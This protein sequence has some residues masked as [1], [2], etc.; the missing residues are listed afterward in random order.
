MK[1]TRE[2]NY[3]I[4]D[5]K[6]IWY[7]PHACNGC[8]STVIV[9]QKNQGGLALDA[10]HNHHYPNHVWEKHSCSQQLQKLVPLKIPDGYYC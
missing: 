3:K 1:L 6:G 8:G 10:P 7:G 4:F 2:E 5:P 9:L